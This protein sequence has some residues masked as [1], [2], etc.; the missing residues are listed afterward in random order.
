M[1]WVSTLSSWIAICPFGGSLPLQ[2][3]PFPEIKGFARRFLRKTIASGFYWQPP[4]LNI[5]GQ[6]DHKRSILF[7]LSTTWSGLMTRPSYW[8]ANRKVCSGFTPQPVRSVPDHKQLQT[9]HR[10][11]NSFRPITS[12]WIAIVHFG[13]VYLARELCIPN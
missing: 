8:P 11:D 10:K 2:T 5:P 4:W 6:T 1:H 7:L 9:F 3:F 13:R 12:I